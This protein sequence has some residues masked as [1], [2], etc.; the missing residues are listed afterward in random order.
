MGWTPVVGGQGGD[1][2]S[3]EGSKCK[4]LGLGGAGFLIRELQT[5]WYSYVKGCAETEGGKGRWDPRGG[6]GFC[7]RGWVLTTQVEGTHSWETEV[8]RQ[9]SNRA[10]DKKARCVLQAHNRF[11]K[12][13]SAGRN[14]FYLGGKKKY[15]RKVWGRLNFF[16]FN[17]KQVSWLQGFSEWAIKGEIEFCIS[18][19]YLSM[20]GLFSKDYLVELVICGTHFGTSPVPNLEHPLFK[21]SASGPFQFLSTL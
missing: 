4:F 21:W 6:Q 14:V 3:R 2:A 20:G 8:F 13:C 12:G 9:F 10:S 11:P 17:I 15:G 1:A 5:I 16:F 7:T 19:T 18:W